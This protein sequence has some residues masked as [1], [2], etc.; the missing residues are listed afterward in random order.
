M[1][2]KLVT[3]LSI[4]KQMKEA[5]IEQSSEFKYCG[6]HID[7]SEAIEGNFEKCEN[8]D[9]LDDDE[10]C[11][12]AGLTCEF[13]IAAFTAGELMI[14]LPY[15][16]TVN[17]TD[18]YLEILKIYSGWDVSYRS[19][20]GELLMSKID[21]ISIEAL[22]LMLLHLKKEGLIGKEGG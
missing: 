14:I 8:T 17:N 11:H 2:E 16:V 13:T 5:G 21:K 10:Y 3:S 7:Y 20:Q 6:G 4:S 19:S 18:Y 9:L 15:K 1:N 12:T 22:G